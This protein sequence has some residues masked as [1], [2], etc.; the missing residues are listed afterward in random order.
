MKPINYQQFVLTSFIATF[1]M[2]TILISM[3]KGM[4]EV[5]CTAIGGIM[6]ILTVYLWKTNI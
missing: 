4:T 6:T 5:A 3:I 2:L 1:L